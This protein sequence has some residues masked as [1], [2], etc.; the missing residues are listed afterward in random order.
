M[1]YDTH[2]FAKRDADVGCTNSLTCWLRSLPDFENERN[3]GPEWRC[4][5]IDEKG[6]A[7]LIVMTGAAFLPRPHTVSTYFRSP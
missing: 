4:L 5:N 3:M 1:R 6:R 2:G 7:V